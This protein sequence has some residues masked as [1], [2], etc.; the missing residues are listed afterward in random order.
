[1]TTDTLTLQSADDERVVFER[2]RLL[3]QFIEFRIVLVGGALKPR[4][5][6]CFL[7]FVECP[8]RPLEL[9]YGLLPFADHGHS[10]AART[11]ALQAPALP[12]RPDGALACAACL[13]SGPPSSFQ[14]GHI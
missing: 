11:G 2:G 3:E 6:Q 5:H 7:R 13:W 10:L 12:R 8:A 4:A 9:Q 1:M 14:L